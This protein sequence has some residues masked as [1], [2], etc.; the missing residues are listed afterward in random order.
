MRGHP[1][2]H[3][4]HRRHDFRL[5]RALFWWFGITILL[6]CAVSFGVIRLVSPEFHSWRRNMERLETFAAGRFAIVWDDPAARRELVQSSAT[7]FNASIVMRDAQGRTL[8]SA[9]GECRSGG[10]EIDVRRGGVLLGMVRG[11]MHDQRFPWWGVPATLFAAFLTIWAATAKLARRLTRPLQDLTRV[12]REIGEG[13]LES[14]VRLGHH[15][16]GEVGILADS[17]NDMAKRIERQLKDQRELLAGVSHE[18]RSPLARL[19]VL[20]ELL[21]SGSASPDLHQKIELEVAEID[22]LVGKLLASSRLDFGALELQ[23]LQARDVALRALERASLPAELL[24]DSSS[25]APVRGDATLLARALGNLLENAQHH[26]GG[27]QRFALRNEDSK[28][29]FE[30]SDRGPGLSNEALA[31][32]F[33]PFFRG[34]HDGQASSRGALGLGLSLVR[35]IAR[36]H[37]GDA[38]IQNRPEGGAV[39]TLWLPRET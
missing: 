33:D 3:W 4:R 1:G 30:V 20:S 18:I 25:G 22:D 6:A 31:H 21:R 32:G 34:N 12:T 37:A 16:K 26:A 11:C 24:D 39:A 7:A 35:R 38:E 28:V 10:M 9:G 14:R 5:Q 17:I 15:H 23:P 27:V 36:A 29:V 8:E 19:R 13:K 2:H